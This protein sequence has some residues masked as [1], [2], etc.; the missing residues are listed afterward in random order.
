M[1]GRAPASCLGPPEPRWGWGGGRLAT[2]GRGAVC[3]RIRLAPAGASGRAL[4]CPPHCSRAGPWGHTSGPSGGHLALSLHSAGPRVAS[5]P[6]SRCPPTRSPLAGGEREGPHCQAGAFS[7][8][9]AGSFGGWGC[10]TSPQWCPRDAA[11]TGKAPAGRG[12]VPRAGTVLPTCLPGH[13]ACLCGH[14]WVRVPV[15]VC[16]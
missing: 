16:V 3:F 10:W 14:V 2:E 5:L 13:C 11:G 9:E 15:L 7:A 1:G 8:P 12:A 4:P 6:P